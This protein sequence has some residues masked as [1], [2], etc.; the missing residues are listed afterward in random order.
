MTPDMING[1][2]EASGCVFIALS[3]LKLRKEKLVRGV[4]WVHMS[5]FMV[6]G[7]WNLFYYP[8]LDQWISFWGGVGIVT[9]NTLYVTQLIYY[10][11]WEGGRIP[12]KWF[13]KH[14]F[15][16]SADLARRCRAYSEINR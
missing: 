8:H 6:W 13:V 15:S 14:G 16:R 10:T 1:L 3:I 12:K 5:F 11:R 4:S 7:F 2:F 9:A